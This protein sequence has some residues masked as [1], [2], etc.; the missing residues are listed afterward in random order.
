MGVPE[1]EDLWNDLTAKADSQILMGREEA[2]Q[3][4]DEDLRL[5]SRQPQAAGSRNPRGQ[6]SVKALRR[7]WFHIVRSSPYREHVVVFCVTQKILKWGDLC[8]SQGVWLIN[9]RNDPA[10]VSL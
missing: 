4:T 9:G 7:H 1:M 3:E 10:P 8:C 5:S 2:L 6:G